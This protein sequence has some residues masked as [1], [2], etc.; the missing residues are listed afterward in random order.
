M[1]A[2]RRADFPRVLPEL[3][4]LEKSPSS[5]SPRCRG[6]A[7]FGAGRRHEFRSSPNS[8]SVGDVSIPVMWSCLDP[9]RGTNDAKDVSTSPARPGTVDG[10][11]SHARRRTCP[12]SSRTSPSRREQFLVH[13]AGY[14]RQFP[15]PIGLIPLMG[16]PIFQNGSDTVVQRL[17]DA[18]ATTGAAINTQL[19]GLGRRGGLSVALDPANLAND[20]GTMS[21]LDYVAH[22]ARHG[23]RWH[24]RRYAD[25]LLS[26]EHQRDARRH[27]GRAVHLDGHVG[28][29][30]ARGCE[31]GDRLQDR[32]RHARRSVGQHPC[33]FQFSRSRAQHLDHASRGGTDRAGLHRPASPAASLSAVTDWPAPGRTIEGIRLG[34]GWSRLGW[35]R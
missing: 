2:H 17:A 3:R 24:D 19:T 7:G 5:S 6:E 9:R 16:D 33:R 25:R 1:S 10:L 12:G 18:D 15:P 21:F 31:R 8:Q 14:R 20:V 34:A 27:R 13:T 23:D 4:P 28:G 29:V 11:R 32:P 35:N 26:G 22:R 30:L